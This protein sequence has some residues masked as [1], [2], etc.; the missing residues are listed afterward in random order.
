MG[1]ALLSYE[2]GQVQFTAAQALASGEIIQLSD[3][4]AGVIAGLSAIAIGEAACAYTRG[5]FLAAAATGVTFIEGETVFWDA[6][7][8]TAINSEDTGLADFALGVA[9]AA[10]VSGVLVVNVDLNAHVSRQK[11]LEIAAATTLTAADLG[12]TVYGDTQAGAFSVTL[13]TAASCKGGRFTFIRAGTGV[14]ALTLDGDA[15]ETVDNAT[16]VATMD[17]ARDTLTIES[18]GSA[19]FIVAARLA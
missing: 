18:N 15:S 5:I 16:T 19:W 12:A 3:G 9:V 8:N 11:I 1:E 10:K 7:A 17:A 6:S 13:P 2:A 14:N 4:R